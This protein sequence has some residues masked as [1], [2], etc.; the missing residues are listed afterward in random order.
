MGGVGGQ[1]AVEMEEVKRRLRGRCRQGHLRL[2]PD[3]KMKKK[4]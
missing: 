1:G 2:E 4:N 3:I